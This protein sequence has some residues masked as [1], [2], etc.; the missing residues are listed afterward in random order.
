MKTWKKIGQALSILA[1]VGT[2]W[3]V[4][5]ILVFSFE[6]SENNNLDYVPE[7]ATSVYRLDGK[8][9]TRELLATLLIS[10][11]ED[12]K[13]LAQSEIPTTDGG[14]L[15][16][17]GISFDSDILLFR[18]EEDETI[19]SGM[20]FNLWDAKVFLK[21][22]PK[23]IGT[24]SA[25]AAKEDVGLILIQLEGNN[26]QGDLKKRAQKMLR[27][28]TRFAKKHS[29]TD[30][31]SLI[32]V[33][34]HDEN[35]GITD[36]GL[37]VQDNQLLFTG[38]VKSKRDLNAPTLPQYEGGFHLHSSWIPKV[39][40]D[41]ISS[42]LGTFGMKLPALKQ[43][44]INYFGATI[45]T[46]PSVAAMPHMAGAFEFETPVIADS[47]FKDFE[48]TERDSIHQTKVYDIFS[49]SYSVRQLNATTISIQS[50]EGID[51]K[52]RKYSSIA[53]VSG[54]PQHLVELDGDSFIKRIIV[55]TSEFKSVS[56]F[57]KEV[58][59]LDIKMTP[60]STDTYRIRGKIALKN[61]KWPLNELLKF[62]IRSKLF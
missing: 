13:S 20:L 38:Q 61:D 35:K 24:N 36:I 40:N 8:V 39:L 50:K 22:L 31:N 5:T 6:A 57:V 16:P 23:Y 52:E 29:W 17:V 28:K 3:L 62:L 44:S 59:T 54:V 42:G 58:E 27:K 1:L 2:L 37:T 14:Q 49:I 12:L 9:L 47:I 53:E 11:D 15:K 45:I 56:G 32:S 55:F 18:L 30:E 4:Y 43:F 21:N 7:N 33:W 46:E 25:I 19:Y 26:T 34:Y 60:A 10:E 41:Q 51:V 48:I